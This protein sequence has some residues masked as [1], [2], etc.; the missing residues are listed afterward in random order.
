MLVKPRKSKYNKNRLQCTKKRML[1][2]RKQVA[3]KRLRN[4]Y[5]TGTCAAAAAKAAAAFF[6]QATRQKTF[7]YSELTLPGGGSCRIPVIPFLKEGEPFCFGVQKD[8]GDDPDVTNQTLILA[9]VKP[10]SRKILEMLK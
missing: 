5:T 6:A 8:S 4:G 7:T 3:E 9:S 1:K 2:R 10:V